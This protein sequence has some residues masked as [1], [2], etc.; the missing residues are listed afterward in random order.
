MEKQ[1]Q[2][3]WYGRYMDLFNQESDRACVIL[4]VS[5]ID[6][7]LTSILKMKLVDQHS[8]NDTLFDGANAP[9]SNFNSKIDISYRLG[10][11]SSRLCRDIHLIRRIRNE[12]A[13]NIEGCDFKDSRVQNRVGEL[14]KSFSDLII[15][16]RTIEA[17]KNYAEGIKGDFQFCASWIIDYLS[18]LSQTIT[19]MTRHELEWSY[20]KAQIDQRIK[21]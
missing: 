2:V 17:A 11:L 7:L 1:Y 20:V 13:H 9:F 18:T 4:T 5:I 8:S 19:P 15:G 3:Q 14:T 12:F 21:K 10:V 6:E 16:F